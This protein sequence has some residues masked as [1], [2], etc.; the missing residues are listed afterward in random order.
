MWPFSLPKDFIDFPSVMRMKES[1]LIVIF[2]SFNGQVHWSERK[3]RRRN[4]ET[5]HYTEHYRYFIVIS[6][7][8][9]IIIIINVIIGVIII[10]INVSISTTQVII[11]IV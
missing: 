2:N 9:A 10:I 7:I 3:T 6:V 4:G 8:I 1:I 11:I 5:E